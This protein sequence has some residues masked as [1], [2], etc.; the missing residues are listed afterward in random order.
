[1]HPTLLPVTTMHQI[2]RLLVTIVTCSWRVKTVRQ[3]DSDALVSCDV[4]RTS[5]SCS[6]TLNK[7]SAKRDATISTDWQGF[8]RK[9][10]G[11]S[12]KTLSTIT[13]L[14]VTEQEMLEG[15]EGTLFPHLEHFYTLKSY[16]SWRTTGKQRVKSST[17]GAHY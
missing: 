7:D 5:F 15:E 8:Q 2:Y 12:V 11:H 3:W 10:T 14:E 13:S 9:I 4:A 6:S 1:M 16:Q 17:L